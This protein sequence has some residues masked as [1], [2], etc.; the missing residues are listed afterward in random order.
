[1]AND[2]NSIDESLKNALLK[3]ALGYEYEEKTIEANREGKTTG[4]KIVKKYM[5]P[6]IKAISKIIWL[7]KVGRW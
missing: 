7:K 6:D 5:P 1:M 3:R 2:K 4:I